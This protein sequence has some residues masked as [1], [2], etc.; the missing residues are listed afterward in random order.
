MY[1]VYSNTLRSKTV[2]PKQFI[3]EKGHSGLVCGCTCGEMDPK[4]GKVELKRQEVPQ[5]VLLTR[6]IAVDLATPL[7]W[8]SCLVVMGVEEGCA[9]M[10][11]SE[12]LKSGQGRSSGSTER[13]GS[14][15]HASP[16]RALPFANAWLRLLSMA[17]PSL[18]RLSPTYPLEIFV[19]GKS[20]STEQSIQRQSD[21]P[22][23]FCGTR[24]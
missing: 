5:S 23:K 9:A 15:P 8:A 7:R 18:L 2:P 19:A 16:S 21:R 24:S 12:E 20:Q 22:A 1:S 11:L 14:L 10:G 4:S 13:T 17:W 6:A 3:T